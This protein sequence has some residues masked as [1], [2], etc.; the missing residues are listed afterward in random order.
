MMSWFIC[1]NKSNYY[2]LKTTPQKIINKQIECPNVY[3][4]NRT[5]TRNNRKIKESHNYLFLIQK[6]LTYTVPYVFITFMGYI[7]V[8]FIPTQAFICFVLIIFCGA[9][10][11]CDATRQYARQV[12]RAGP[13]PPPTTDE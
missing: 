9:V 11:M 4:K 13:T 8:L 3:Y 12:R 10:T 2:V 6:I 5:P 1:P 7:V